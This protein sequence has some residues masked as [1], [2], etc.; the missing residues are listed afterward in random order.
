MY[1]NKITFI[2]D[3]LNTRHM[4]FVPVSFLVS[5]V[6]IICGTLFMTSSRT[7]LF[8]N[9]DC[10]KEQKDLAWTSVNL[11]FWHLLST[12]DNS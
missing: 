12:T 6:A 11:S 4:T 3:F 9:Y 2:T 1:S 5:Y 10:F 7:D 8:L